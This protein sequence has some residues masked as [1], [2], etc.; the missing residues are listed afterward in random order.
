[1]ADRTELLGRVLQ[2]IDEEGVK[3]ENAALV[4]LHRKVRHLN[5]V[6]GL[7][8]ACLFAALILAAIR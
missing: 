5:R 7:L 2:A 6:I 1:M 8:V 4:R 3:L